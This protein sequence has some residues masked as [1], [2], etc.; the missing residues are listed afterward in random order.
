[1]TEFITCLRF[2]PTTKHAVG[3]RP[4]G[5][6]FRDSVKYR[7]QR[8]DPMASGVKADHEHPLPLGAR[9]GLRAETGV[10]S[11]RGVDYRIGVFTSGGSAIR[12]QGGLRW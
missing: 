1:M 2:A 3:K 10:A 4:D 9:Q 7:R 8:V 11:M 5:W 6:I 12:K